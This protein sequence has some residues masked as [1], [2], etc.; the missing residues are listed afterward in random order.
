M[1]QI[2]LSGL[3]L[4]LLLLRWSFA[5]A[6]SV[7][8]PND[9]ATLPVMSFAGSI[10]VAR[11]APIGTVLQ[12]VSQGVGIYAD[13]TC[14]VRKVISVDGIPVP[15]TPSTFQTNVPGIGVVFY[16]TASWNGSWTKAPTVESLPATSGGKAHYTRADLVI[17]GPVASGS[18]TVLPT[19]TT[20]F[21]GDCMSTVSGTQR[22]SSGTLITSSTCSVITSSIDVVLPK[23]FAVSLATAGSTT[24]ASPLSIGLDCAK[25]VKIYLTISDASDFS[26]RTTTLSL[27]QG[28]SASGVGVQLVNGST[29]VS[30]GPD[31][32]TAGTINQWFAATG[33]GGTIQIPLTARYV[34]T[35]GPLVPGTV[36]ALATFT[37]SYQ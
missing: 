37:M 31:S 23:V 13:V 32:A 19:M 28:S 26:N 12:S 21:S 16:E 7:K 27:A 36:K 10:A 29:P 1:M 18:L 11:N 25:N 30:Y 20:T 34:R 8:Y 2:P 22:L 24:G 35:S 33:T 6:G 14:T 5:L 17:T 3:L 15:E 9:F 4:L